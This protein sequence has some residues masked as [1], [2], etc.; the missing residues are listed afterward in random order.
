MRAG[1][2]AESSENRRDGLA[3]NPWKHR[4]ATIVWRGTG[5]NADSIPYTG[6][7]GENA[8]RERAARIATLHPNIMD[9][10]LTHCVG[11]QCDPASSGQ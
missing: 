3:V 7:H 9:I 11:N 8:L 1:L 4:L 5:W 6:N 10:K 2:F